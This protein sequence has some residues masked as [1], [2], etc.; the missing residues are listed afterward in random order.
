MSSCKCLFLSAPQLSCRGS[1]DTQRPRT[2]HERDTVS[3][4][5]SF[6][7]DTTTGEPQRSDHWNR[8]LPRAARFRDPTTA[9]CL[10]PHA[11]STESRQPA[12][13]HGRDAVAYP[14]R[15]LLLSRWARF[16]DGSSHACT[17]RGAST[18]LLLGAI[19]APSAGVRFLMA[20][21]CRWVASLADSSA[22]PVHVARTQPQRQ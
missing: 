8:L 22:W 13:S 11:P 20:L 1:A 14:A 3:A 7:N 18:H 19:P 9:G 16:A 21:A 12:A 6:R 2:T 10:V 5:G 15:M 4:G 17:V